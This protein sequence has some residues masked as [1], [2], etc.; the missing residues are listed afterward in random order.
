M[1]CKDVFDEC[2]IMK[3]DIL[4][5]LLEQ[6]SLNIIYVGWWDVP[7]AFYEEKENGGCQVWE[8]KLKLAL[9]NL[10]SEL[11]NKGYVPGYKNKVKWYQEYGK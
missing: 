8:G 7:Y 10:D 3:I 4:H 9:Y 11:R 2:K 1:Y 6:A 5:F